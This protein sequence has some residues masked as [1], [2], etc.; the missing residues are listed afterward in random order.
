MIN[1]IKRIDWFLYCIVAALWGKDNR[2]FKQGL[3]VEVGSACWAMPILIPHA[4]SMFFAGV[5]GPSHRLIPVKST[6]ESRQHIEGH[7]RTHL[8][9]LTQHQNI[10][11]KQQ[12][13]IPFK[14][15]QE[16]YDNFAMGST[17]LTLALVAT[18]DLL[19]HK[20]HKKKGV[21][22]LLPSSRSITQLHDSTNNFM[23]AC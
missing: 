18:G 12:M 1:Y 3:F 15:Q 14:I 4:K 17:E 23:T 8:R 11:R 13:E 20:A 9:E 21:E 16:R 2:V 6:A 10:L 19:T 22:A 5:R 7:Y